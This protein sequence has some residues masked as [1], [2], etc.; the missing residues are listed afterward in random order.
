MK[1]SNC[2][3]RAG[4]SRHAMLAI[5]GLLGLVDGAQAFVIDTGN[6]DVQM[7]WGNTLRYNLGIRAKQR[8]SVIANSPNNDEGTYSYKRGEVVTNRLDLLSEFEASYKKQLGF[9]LT[10][11]AWADAAFHDDVRTNPAFAARGSY[12]DNRFSDYTK[13]YSGGPSGEFLDAFVFGNFKLDAMSG[14]VKAGRHVNLWGE[15]LVLSAHSVSYAQAPSDGL[16]AL[17]TPG[18]DAKETALPVGQISGTLQATPRLA[19][20]G[21]YFYEWRPTRIAEGGTYLGGTD[22]ILEGPDRLSLTPALFLSNRGV[23]K[24]KEDGEWGVSARWQ[25][26]WLDEGTIGFYYRKFSE[27][28]PTISLN[29]ANRTYRAVYPENAKLYGISLSKA[30]GGIS[31][32]VEIVRRQN[33]AFNSSITDGASEGARGNTW[34]GLVNVVQAYG[35]T[36]LWSSA[37][38]T[39]ELAYSRWDDVTSG[40]RYF[41][42]C[43]RRPAGDRDVSTGCV[44]KDSVQG[45]L[46]FSPTWNAVWPGWDISANASYLAG[47]KGNSAVLGGGN[48]RTGSYTLG[49]TFTYNNQHDFSVAYNGYLATHEQNAAGAIRVSNGSQIQDRGWVAFTYKG[50]F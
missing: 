10:G 46:R 27:R 8:D 36:S 48:F 19:L 47:L 49:L 9:R 33:T 44:T 4:A 31:T 41:L 3:A 43:Y 17:T 16:K 11:A 50:S 45:F 32:G 24:P 6:P 5:A 37:I 21:Q 39:A 25:P 2:I 1:G 15:A 22:F 34:H 7:T 26:E 38:L 29:L 35:Q 14:N 40:E 20:S 30:F 42:A 28:S 12:V 23:T 18:V 13:R